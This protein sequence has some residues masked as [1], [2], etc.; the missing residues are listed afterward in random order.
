MSHSCAFQAKLQSGAAP[1]VQ[2]AKEDLERKKK[3]IEAKYRNIVANQCIVFA[4]A[5]Q[6]DHQV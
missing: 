5:F 1:T 3:E 4:E 6:K 2:D